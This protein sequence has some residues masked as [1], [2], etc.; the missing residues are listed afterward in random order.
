MLSM[1]PRRRP[2]HERYAAAAKRVQEQIT[3]ALENGNY[4][5][6][7]TLSAILQALARKASKRKT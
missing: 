7:R 1:S 5:K 6:V 2:A 3:R 4:G